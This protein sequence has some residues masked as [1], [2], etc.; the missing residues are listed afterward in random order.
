MV[1]NPNIRI[2]PVDIGL[3]GTR[4]CEFSDQELYSAFLSTDPA[5]IKYTI[6]IKP[7]PV[8]PSSPPVFTAGLLWRLH[9]EDSRWI[10][11]AHVPG[12]F[13]YLVGNFTSDFHS[14]DIF[15]SESVL[16][17]GKL[18]FP[19]SFPTGQVLTTLLLGTGYG[20]MLHSCG[21]RDSACGYVFAGVSSSG[22]TT[23]ACLWNELEGVRV[24]NDERTI[25]CKDKGEFRVYGTPWH[26]TGGFALPN[27]AVAKNVFIIK[28]SSS[29]QAV[30]LSPARAAAAL[31]IS[32]FAPFWDASAMAF[33]LQFLDE[34]C[35]A[36]PVYELGFVPDQSAVEYVRCLPS[37]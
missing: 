32:T 12:K 36:V 4:G 22:K 34:L 21:I 24:L 10:L 8:E 23:T 19:F 17:P 35:H 11:W 6:K 14:G 37:G 3:I 5:H 30:R 18:V 1:D 7:Q 15:T 13:P 27:N 16:E 2:G 26:G 33:T 31:M 9:K 28:H 20:V 29:N 25:I